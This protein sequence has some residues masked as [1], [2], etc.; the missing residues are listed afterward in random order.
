MANPNMGVA[1]DINED[2][3]VQA[4]RWLA[5]RFV[6]TQGKLRIQWFDLPDNI[7]TTLGE[8]CPP[9]SHIEKDLVGIKVLLKV[10]NKG[11]SDELRQSYYR[12][13]VLE[14]FE[15]SGVTTDLLSSG[16]FTCQR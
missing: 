10:V 4:T 16:Y 1:V 14:H 9:L 11:I 2:N 8:C 3:V 7:F 13:S 5:T 15:S 12:I 6:N